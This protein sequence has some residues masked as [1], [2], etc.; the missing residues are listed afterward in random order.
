MGI[1]SFQSVKGGQVTRSQSVLLSLNLT[2]HWTLSALTTC[3]EN[4][5]SLKPMVFRDRHHVLHLE[6]S[7][8]RYSTSNSRSRPWLQ[9][10]K[11]WL[12]SNSRG[13]S[14]S[15]S[16]PSHYPHPRHLQCLHKIISLLAI[17]RIYQCPLSSHELL[18]SEQ[19]LGPDKDHARALAKILSSG[20]MP[21]VHRETQRRS[22]EI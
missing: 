7:V 1:E 12:P 18:G 3:L 13:R 17:L 9:P 20:S 19:H 14:A 21:S 5:Q 10:N 8:L 22:I 6:V 15:D 11:L 2:S 4:S 16:S